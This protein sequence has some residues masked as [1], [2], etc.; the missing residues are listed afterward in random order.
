MAIQNLY[1]AIRPSLD[2]NFAG[3]KTVDPRITFTRASSATYFDEFGVM[4]TVSS[5]VPRIDHNPVTGECLGLLVE[6]Q[7]TNLLT[8][9]EQ[10]DNAAWHKLG[11][12]VVSANAISAPDGTVSAD[13]I[14]NCTGY[15]NRFSNLTPVTISGGGTYTFSV[16]VRSSG[17]GSKAMLQLGSSGGTYKTVSVVKS[18]A[19]E[20]NRFDLQITTNSDNTGL[21]VII[22]GD[23]GTS[24]F[25]V[26]GAQLEAGAFP[27][28]YIPTTSAQVT[29][30][31]DSAVMTGENFSSWYRQD[32]GTFVATFSRAVAAPDTRAPVTFSVIDGTDYMALVGGM[33]VPQHQ[34]FDVALSGALTAQIN[35]VQNVIAGQGFN[36]S[37]AYKTNDIAASYNG[38]TV[39]TDTSSPVPAVNNMVIGGHV[40]PIHALNGHIRRIAYYPKRLANA[41][42]QA[43]T[44]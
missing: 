41:K 6:E 1:P 8:Y 24:E 5:N 31:A 35:V 34:R 19:Q 22:Y 18:L 11:T 13:L 42:L 44:Q 25:Y 16:Y 29:R 4:R 28:S 23:V 39:L 36:A 3:S 43:L 38:T 15:D 33:A 7:R 2:L 37:V 20:W 32:E 12:S 26:W 14:S 9:S 40:A 10:F 30:A 27:T 17:N 21:F